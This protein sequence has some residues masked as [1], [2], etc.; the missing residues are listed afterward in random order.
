MSAPRVTVIVPCRDEAAHIEACL[1]SILSTA[2]PLER[3]EV[4]V[5]D[6][7]SRD[8]TR[9]V[10]ASCARRHPAIRLLDNPA[11]TAPAALNIGIRAARGDIIARMDAH[12]VYPREY[13]PRLV[14]A[15]QRTGADNVGGRLVTLPA[16]DSAAAHGIALAL[17]HPLGVG[18]SHFRIGCAAPRWVDTVPFGCYRREVFARVGGFDEELVRNQ[19]DEFNHRLRQHGGTVLLVPDVV[20][21]YYARRSRRQVWRMFYQYGYFKPLAA[22][23]LGRVATARQLAPPALVVGG[24][25]GALLAALWSPALVPWLALVAVYQLVIAGAAAR[26]VPQHGPR[27]ALAFASVVPLLHVSYGLGFLRGLWDAWLAPG[28]HAPSAARRLSR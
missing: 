26:A 12:A 19:D 17:A 16:D 13:L 6:G 8:G 25:G 24:V 7:R 14:E 9:D 11:G 15:L 1:A 3:L 10:I 2:Y 28:R 21:Y 20:A 4:L 18:N 27:R 22:R 23:K 5:V